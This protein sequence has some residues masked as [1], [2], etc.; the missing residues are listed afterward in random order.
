MID[1][2]LNEA[3]DE[4]VAVVIVRLQAKLQGVVHSFGGGGQ[5]LGEE[6]F[7]RVEVVGGPL[8]DE[9]FLARPAECT[10][11]LRRIVSLPCLRKCNNSV[12][13]F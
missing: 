6:L 8:V 1:V 9:N 13:T 5:V 4:P 11:E 12:T 7:L 3:L 2:V 10:N